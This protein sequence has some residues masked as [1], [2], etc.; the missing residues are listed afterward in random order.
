LDKSNRFV[1]NWHQLF[2]VKVGDIVVG[3]KPQIQNNN[4]A[5]YRF[6]A[7]DAIAGDAADWLSVP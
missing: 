3:R 7:R 4:R 1:L 5:P 6:V 2:Q